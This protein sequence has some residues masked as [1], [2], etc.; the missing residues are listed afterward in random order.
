M[1]CLWY[2]TWMKTNQTR[3]DSFAVDIY[4]CEVSSSEH[5]FLDTMTSNTPRSLCFATQARRFITHLS[6]SKETETAS[7]ICGRL[8]TEWEHK[9]RVS[10]RIFRSSV[11]EK[12]DRYNLIAMPGLFTNVLHESSDARNHACWFFGTRAIEV[13]IRWPSWTWAMTI[14]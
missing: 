3:G 10:A 9:R 12:H 6:W 5:Q 7:S 13:V 1:E 2:Y 11:I 4:S 8:A 14:A